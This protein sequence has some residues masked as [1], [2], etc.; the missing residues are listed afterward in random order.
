MMM[1]LFCLCLS[2][3][4]I[5]KVS[6]MPT[7]NHG[8]SVLPAT[9]NVKVDGDPSEWNLSQTIFVCGDV[10]PPD[11]CSKTPRLQYGRSGSLCFCLHSKT[12]CLRTPIKTG[13]K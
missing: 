10:S 2:T 12:P 3:R 5:G 1:A 4:L 9:G 11:F 6:A 8:M 7:E 13:R